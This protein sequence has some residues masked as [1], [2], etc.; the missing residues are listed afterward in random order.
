MYRLKIR[1]DGWPE[2]HAYWVDDD[3]PDIHPVGWCSKT[4]HPLEP[5]LSKYSFYFAYVLQNILIYA[6]LY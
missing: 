1:F 2:T 6:M 5:P 3:S 4:G